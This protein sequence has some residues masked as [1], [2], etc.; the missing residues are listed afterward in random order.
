MG[1]PTP[2]PPQQYQQPPPPAAGGD[3]SA[4]P[5]PNPAQAYHQMPPAAAGYPQATPQQQQAYMSQQTPVATPQFGIPRPP[6]DHNRKESVG[7]FG[8]DWVMGGT[9]STTG[10]VGGVYEA[11]AAAT[12]HAEVPGAPDNSEAAAK[13]EELRK[14]LKAAQEIA[15]DAAA[16]HIKLAQEADEL[17][18]DADKA[19]ANARGLRAASEKKE[20]K[21]FGGNSKK[22]AMNVSFGMVDSI[23]STNRLSVTHVLHLNS[24]SEMRTMPQQPPM[25]FAN[26]S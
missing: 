14:K 21:R 16:T 13:V 26:D 19:E 9:V 8:G 25:I 1:I 6:V 15:S 4:I 2:T 24:H 11:A 17:R 23:L 12:A 7:G 3:P 20:K 10:A 18:G 22:K 5:T